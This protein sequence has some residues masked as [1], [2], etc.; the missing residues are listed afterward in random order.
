MPKRSVPFLHTE[1]QENRGTWWLSVVYYLTFFNILKISLLVAGLQ[2]GFTVKPRTIVNY[3]HP[4]HYKIKGL[5][6]CKPLLN[7]QNNYEQRWPFSTRWTKPTNMPSPGGCRPPKKPDTRILSGSLWE[8]LLWFTAIPEWSII[9]SIPGTRRRV[10]FGDK[11]ESSLK[12]PVKWHS[13]FSIFG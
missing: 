11:R 9:P 12:K 1:H 10:P 8:P 6:T 7:F 4:I 3:W 13:P 5:Y 2:S